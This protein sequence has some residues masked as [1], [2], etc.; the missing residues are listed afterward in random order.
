MA[1]EVQVANRALTKLGSFRILSLDDDSKPARAIKSCFDDLRDDELRS[2]GWQFALKRV[3]LVASAT[4]PDHG[5]TYQYPLPADFLALD[6]VN[7][8]FPA[9]S[10]DDYITNDVIEYSHEANVIMT[11]FPSPLKVRYI[12]RIT[13]PNQWDPNFRE[14]LACRI[15]VEV[16][17]E[18]TQS[19][20]KRQLAWDE[21]KRALVRAITSNSFERPPVMLADDSWI[22]GRI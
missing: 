7:D 11:D 13:D 12:A 19:G 18:L 2:Y 21:Y 15:A 3:Q 6:M 8:Q 17:E 20:P 4:A 14:V 16:A 9:V 10:L 1:S 5:W 22:M